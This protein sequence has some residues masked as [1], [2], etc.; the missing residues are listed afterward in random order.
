MNHSWTC[1][2][3]GKRY[4]DLILSLALEVPDTWLNIPESEIAERGMIS[5]DAC[6]IDGQH[7]FVRGCLE[8][9][10]IGR[11]DVFMYGV[12]VSVSVKNF[13]RIGA[14]WDVEVRDNEPPMFAWL[15]NNIA[16]YPQ[17]FGLKTNL[18]LRNGGRRPLVEIEPT[19]HPLAIKQRQGITLDRVEEIVS[20]LRL[21]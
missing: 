18:H 6:I 8:I 3:C 16:G 7:F 1:A 13:A 12:W 9:P 2:C 5:S 21:H 17:T 19:D 11:A 15:C 4:D 20:Q 10:I 14:L